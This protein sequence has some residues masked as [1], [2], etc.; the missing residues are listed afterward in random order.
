MIDNGFTPEWIQL[1]KEIR[2]DTEDL[3]KQLVDARNRLGELPL[4][5]E[6]KY[7]WERALSDSRDT[8]QRI[9]KKVDK[10]NLLVPILQKQML[11]INLK[12]LADAVLAVPPDKSAVSNVKS[13][14]SSTTDMS[15]GNF[16]QFLASIFGK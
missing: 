16:V 4:S 1:S 11:Q 7:Q 12:A 3:R 14:L 8:V 15:E 10:Y 2:E 13:N 9:N 5:P 6:D